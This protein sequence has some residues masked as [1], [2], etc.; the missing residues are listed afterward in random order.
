M[1]CYERDQTECH[2]GI[3]AEVAQEIESGLVVIPLE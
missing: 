1:L 2:R 3:I